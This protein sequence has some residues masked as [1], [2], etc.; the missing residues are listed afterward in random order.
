MGA[1]WHLIHTWH[2]TSEDAA[3]ACTAMNAI[4]MYCNSLSVLTV[5]LGTAIVSL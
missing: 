2:G 3:Q 5:F 1:M 4:R